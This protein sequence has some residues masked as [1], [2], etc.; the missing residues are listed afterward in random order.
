MNMLRL[1]QWLGLQH[2]RHYFDH[3]HLSSKDTVSFMAQLGAWVALQY[4]LLDGRST[5]HSNVSVHNSSFLKD[6]GVNDVIDYKKTSFEDRVHD[7]DVVFDTCGW[8]DA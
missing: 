8:K 1:F 6:L 5:C 4:N 2:G 3:A 7:V